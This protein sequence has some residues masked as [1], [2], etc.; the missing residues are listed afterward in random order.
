MLKQLKGTNL[1]SEEA[2]L[3]F[4]AQSKSCNLGKVM[5]SN[6]LDSLHVS[7]LAC[8]SF[9]RVKITQAFRMALKLSPAQLIALASR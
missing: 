2:L 5:R 7:K 6:K 4:R 8:T 1:T 9:L 3:K